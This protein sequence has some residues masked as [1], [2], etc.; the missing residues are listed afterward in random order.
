M[1]N[2]MNYQKFI[3]NSRQSS[4]QYLEQP[5]QIDFKALF[6]I[7]FELIILNLIDDYMIMEPT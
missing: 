3:L 2:I 4:E 1:D 7:Y 6:E 5:N